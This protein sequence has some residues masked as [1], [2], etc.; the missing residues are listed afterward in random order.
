MIRIFVVVE[1]CF[2]V[3]VLFSVNL[4]R[5]L[6]STKVFILKLFRILCSYGVNSIN[7]LRSCGLNS[8]LKTCVFVQENSITVETVKIQIEALRCVRTVRV[9]TK[10]NDLLE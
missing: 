8:V 3:F 10:S 6:N 5:M 7:R 4:S 1:K 9:F 2:H